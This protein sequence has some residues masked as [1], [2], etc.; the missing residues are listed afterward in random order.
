VLGSGDSALFSTRELFRMPHDVAGNVT[1]KNRLASEGLTLLSG[2]LIDP[3]YGLDEQADDPAGCRLFLHVANIGADPILLRPG[4]DQIARVQFLPVLGGSRVGRDKISPSRW[5][6]QRRA[7]L[8]F[9]TDLKNLKSDVEL[10]DN[11]SQQVVLF[12]FV[13]LA[14]ALIGASFSTILSI[15]TNESL[16]KR[17]HDTWPSS[18]NEAMI[19]VIVFLAVAVLVLATVLGSGS[20][21]GSRRDGGAD[22]DESAAEGALPLLSFGSSSPQ[23][24]AGNG[25]TPR[26]RRGAA[27]PSGP[28]AKSAGV[29]LY[30]SGTSTRMSSMTVSVGIPVVS[31]ST[32]SAAACSGPCSRS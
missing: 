10:S 5:S 19:W 6:E 29:A 21:T 28:T 30:A 2:L 15:A 17:L 26:R 3:G 11:R 23:L 25:K 31:I 4:K 14:F 32:A 8:G 16:N 7:S 13:V 24:P 27:T 9:L 12:G 20:S 1:V 18:S 22:A